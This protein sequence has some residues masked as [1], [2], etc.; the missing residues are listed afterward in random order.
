MVKFYLLGDMGS[1]EIHQKNVSKALYKHMKDKP[2]NIFVCGLGDNIYEDGCFSEDDTQF[3]DKF[4]KPYSNIPN[5]NKFYMCLGNHDYGTDTMGVGNSIHQINYAK[6]SKAD[7]KKWIMDDYYYTFK[8]GN[9]DFFVL[10]TNFDQYVLEPKVVRD[11]MNYMVKKIN[12]SKAKW[13]IVYGHHTWF[14]VGE[15]GGEE[16]S[17]KKFMEELL[18]KC[19]FDVYMCGHDH[20][21]QVIELEMFNK[22]VT[23]VVCGT[24][25]KA[26]HDYTNY[27]HLNNNCNLFFIS[28]NLG[29]GYCNING[30]K[31][32]LDFF[33]DKNKLEYSHEIKKII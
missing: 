31:L 9:V 12:D 5:N 17:V 21:K 1:G 16:E 28:N 4:E 2:K 10:D 22:K 15:H 25:G 33:D 6:K 18:K 13:K 29:F 19:S 27:D 24:G 8:K 14:S 30:N 23:L 7:G 26:Y 32:S 20:N 11:Q 3:K